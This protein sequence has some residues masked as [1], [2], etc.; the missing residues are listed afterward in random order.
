MSKLYFISVTLLLIMSY[1]MEAKEVLDGG[2]CVEDVALSRH[3][4][5]KAVEGLKI[6]K[7]TSFML[8]HPCWLIILLTSKLSVLSVTQS[9]VQQKCLTS[10]LK[11]EVSFRKVDPISGGHLGGRGGGRGGRGSGGCGG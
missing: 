9:V 8:F 4:Q 6:K 1:L 3:H 10:H 11:Q 5:H 7:K 2:G